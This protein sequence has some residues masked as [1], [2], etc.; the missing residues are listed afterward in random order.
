VSAL[1]VSVQKQILDLLADLKKRLGLACLF[2]SHDLGII[3]RISD[4][5]LVMKDGV[6]VESGD[7]GTIFNE[8]QHPYTQTLLS[9]IPRLE[10]AGNAIDI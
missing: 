3:Q 2:I 6:I 7:T 4:R 1:D 5:V 8:P 9:A 10:F